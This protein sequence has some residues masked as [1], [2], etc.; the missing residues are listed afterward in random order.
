MFYFSRRTIYRDLKVLHQKVAC[1]EYLD[2]FKLLEKYCGYEEN[3]I[4]Q[5]EDITNFLKNR[6][7]FTLRPCGGYLTPRDFLAGLAFR[8]FCCTQYMRH[9]SSPYYTPEPDLC[10]EILGHMPMLTSSEFAQFSQEI[11]LAS[12]GAPEDICTALARVFYYFKLSL[13]LP[14][15]LFFSHQL[16]FFTIEFGLSTEGE[17]FDEKRRNLKVY[18]AGLL[19]CFDELKFCVT[20]EAKLKPFEPK[21]VI[22]TEPEVTQFQQCYFYTKSFEEAICKLRFATIFQN[23]AHGCRY[24]IAVRFN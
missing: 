16:Y 5:L 4:P 21:A 17:E 24:I 15:K 10:H 20:S 23:Y 19:S 12:L 3:H 1:K 9:E 7:G 8:V 14:L 11:G 2:N 6:S 18:G 22:A 13:F